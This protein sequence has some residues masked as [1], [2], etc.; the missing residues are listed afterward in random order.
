MWNRTKFIIDPK[1]QFKVVS[2]L[3]IV[4]FTAALAII[5][6]VYF[7]NRH[8]GEY[9]ANSQLS[10]S[11]MARDFADLTSTLLI[12]LGFI[13]VFMVATFM[14]LGFILTHRIAG[15]MYRLRTELKKAVQGERVGKIQFRKDDEFQDLPELINEFIERA[16]RER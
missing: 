8:V 14:A 10:P 13:V 1:L 5:A 7:H 12:R 2:L 16:S 6:T 3:G 4:A 11:A 15:P 9:I